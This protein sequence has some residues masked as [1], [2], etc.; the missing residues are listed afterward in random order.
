MWVIL[1]GMNPW[2]QLMRNRVPIACIVGSAAVLVAL[3]GEL[4]AGTVV[5]ANRTSE[6]VPLQIGDEH[7][8]AAPGESLSLRTESSQMVRFP[9]SVQ[10]IYTVD[11]NAVYFL[12]ARC[13]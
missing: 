3:A 8:R 10:P 11:P 12:C 7:Y 13:A 1:E 9:R 4:R 6:I 5:I 2:L